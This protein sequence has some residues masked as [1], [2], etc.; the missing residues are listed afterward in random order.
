MPD[1][2]PLKIVFALQN[3]QYFDKGPVR[4]DL[5]R[6]AKSIGRASASVLAY[7][8]PRPMLSIAPYRD[9]IQKMDQRKVFDA[10]SY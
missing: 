6:C 7:K 3:P 1:I 5:N 2:L 8:L 9:I 10:A 4:H